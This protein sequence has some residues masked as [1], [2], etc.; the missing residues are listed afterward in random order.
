MIPASFEYTRAATLDEALRELARPDTRAIAGGHSLI[1]LLRFRLAQPGRL[2]DIGGIPELH[3]MSEAGGGLT[4]GATTTYRELLAAPAAQHYPLLVEAASQVGDRQVRN[5]GTVGGGLAHADPAADLPAVML[6]LGAG[7]ECR[8]ARGTRSVAARDFFQ[9]PFTTA[10]AADELLVAITLPPLPRGA[11]TAYAAQEQQ[12]SGYPLAG[13]AAVVTKRNGAVATCV[14]AFTGVGDHA[15]LAASASSL[16]GTAGDAAAC[17]KVAEGAL[18][19]V[20]ITSDLHAPEPYRRHLG[21]VMARRALRQASA[22][23]AA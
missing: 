16:V 6:A 21:M 11:G 4:I 22:A 19:G 3:G 9:G 18:A 20:A 12:A 5:A 15:F 2:V 14:L 17:A 7:F 8:S 23:A 13:A 10:L 1:P